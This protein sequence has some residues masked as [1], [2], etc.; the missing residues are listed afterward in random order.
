MLNL[1]Q[2]GEDLHQLY[3]SEHLNAEITLSVAD[4][5]EWLTG[6]SIS[7]EKQFF[8]MVRENVIAYLEKAAR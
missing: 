1:G 6:I 2:E 4:S 7:S 3:G 8:E 5:P